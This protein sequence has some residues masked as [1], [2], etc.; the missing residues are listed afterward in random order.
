MYHE[1]WILNSPSRTQISSFLYLG[2][3]NDPR[4]PTMQHLRVPRAFQ[5][6]F[7]INVNENGMPLFAPCALKVTCDVSTVN[8]VWGE[9]CDFV[10]RAWSLLHNSAAFRSWGFPTAAFDCSKQID[11]QQGKT[12]RLSEY[13]LVPLPLAWSGIR[14]S[15]INAAAAV[16]II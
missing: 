13:V 10:H 2:E 1:I 9:P 8:V 6:H 11:R 15:T 5:G 4:H 12:I 7:W 3:S 14:G 16:R